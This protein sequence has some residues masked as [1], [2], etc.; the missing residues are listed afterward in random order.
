VIS[1]LDEILG[2]SPLCDC[3]FPYFADPQREI[4]AHRRAGFSFVSIMI[5]T[6]ATA[7]IAAVR[8]LAADRRFY[9]ARPDDFIVAESAD[10]IRKARRDKKLAI[11]F[12]FQGTAPLDQDLSMVVAYYR[13]GIRWMALAYNASNSV[14]GGCMHEEEDQ[15]LTSFGR[16]VVAEMNRV[17]MVV[18]LSHCGYRTSMEAIEHSARPCIF[19]HSN[20]HTLF[21]HPRNVRDDQIVAAARSGGF[22]GINGVGAFVGE[23]GPVPARTIFRHVD[24]MV[25]LVGPQHV[26]IGLEF[27]SPESCTTALA[28]A[29]G[30][31]TKAGGMPPL[32]WHFLPPVAVAQLVGLMLSNGYDHASVRDILGGNF[33][34]VADAVWVPRT[35]QS[36]ET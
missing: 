24:H 3:T 14:G 36:M 30:D 21:P 12:H 23:E 1:D 25:Q 5:A 33:I 7:P 11:G 34:R 9:E 10:D 28:A 26:A 32:P 2:D 8:R 19:S 20:A 29:G 13:L 27:M 15:G 31:P 18:D 22:V 35:P 6:D 17:G 4:A 16:D